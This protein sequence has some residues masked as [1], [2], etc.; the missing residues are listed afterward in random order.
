MST[1]QKSILLVE[2]DIQLAEALSAYLTL[3]QYKTTVADTAKQAFEFANQGNFDLMLLDLTL[4]DEDGL[5]L[6][7]KLRN[8]LKT[9]IIITSGRNDSAD[10]IAGLELGAN[11]YLGKP[12]ATRELELRIEHLLSSFGTNG[13]EKNTS[14]AVGPHTLNLSMKTLISEN[15][16]QISLTPSEYSILQFLGQHPGRVFSREQL[17]DEMRSLDGP[18]NPTAIDI[19]ICRLRK[20]IDTDPKRPSIIVT[21]KGFGYRLGE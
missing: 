17:I 4:P 12:F 20:K 6:L 19:C 9:P 21:V 13:A 5:V 2:D 8:R 11:D 18:E 1:K 10:R 14:I 7:R 3:K 16:Q 15:K